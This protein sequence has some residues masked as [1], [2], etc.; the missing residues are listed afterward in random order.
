MLNQNKSY[1]RNSGNELPYKSREST[2][3]YKEPTKSNDESTRQYKEPTKSNDES[4]Y[5]YKEP[6]KSNDKPKRTTSSEGTSQRHRS[7]ERDDWQFPIRIIDDLTKVLANASEDSGKTIRSM[8]MHALLTGGCLLVGGILGGGIGAAV[9]GAW[10]GVI[11]LGNYKSLY[12]CLLELDG[13]QKVALFQ[14]LTKTFGD[15]ALQTMSSGCI[16]V[17]ELEKLKKTCEEFLEKMK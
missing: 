13:E 15:H 8:K 4:K 6:T 1:Q 14:E 2:R 17:A 9:G 16:G 7:S 10:Y 11:L 5:Q 12:K 3:Q